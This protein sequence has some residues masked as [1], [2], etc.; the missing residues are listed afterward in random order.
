MEWSYAEIR[1]YSAIV[2]VAFS[3]IVEDDEGFFLVRIVHNC[4]FKVC[5]CPELF[6]FLGDGMTKFYE[7]DVRVILLDYA[8]VVL[9][10]FKRPNVASFAL[11]SEQDLLGKRVYNGG[12]NH[13]YNRTYQ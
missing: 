1:N 7:L 12:F 4:I 3:R 2:N 13:K 9:L 5:E 10:S 6:V 11:Y 8:E